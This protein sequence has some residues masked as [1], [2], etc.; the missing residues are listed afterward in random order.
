[1][2]WFKR[3]VKG[4]LTKTNEKKER[5]NKCRFC[6]VSATGLNPARKVGK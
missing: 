5:L 1:M 6:V 4:I 2:S 3:S